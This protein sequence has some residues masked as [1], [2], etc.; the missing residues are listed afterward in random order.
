MAGHSA[1][2]RRKEAAP[3]EFCNHQKI[4]SS[5]ILISNELQTYQ[6]QP[7]TCT[8]ASLHPRYK[9]QSS[10]QAMTVHSRPQIVQLGLALRDLQPPEDVQF[11][12]FCCGRIFKHLTNKPKYVGQQGLQTEYKQLICKHATWQVVAGRTYANKLRT[13]RSAITRK[14][15]AVEF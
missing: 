8:A 10:P 6:I 14:Y 5:G 9:K 1:P 3:C 11:T 15:S 12:A 13:E 4:F 2:F 7:T